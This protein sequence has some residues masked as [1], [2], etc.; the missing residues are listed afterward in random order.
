MARYGYGISVSGSRTP[1]VASSTPAPSGIPVASTNTINVVDTFGYN[2]TIA[3]SKQ[4]STL[5][6]ASVGF[7]YGTIYCQAYENTEDV[8]IYSIGVVKEGGNWIYRY[9]GI[10]NC[11]ETYP[12]D[13]DLA[14]VQEVTS[15]II[16]TTGWSPSL[17]ITAA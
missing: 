11:E 4:N 17:T 15:G 5:Y 16:P 13:Y 9:Y 12:Y 14:T 10:Y 6:N 1:I 2:G 7:A 3:L 8:N